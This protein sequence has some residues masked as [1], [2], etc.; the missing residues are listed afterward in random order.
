M[1]NEHPLVARFRN[2]A[3]LSAEEEARLRSL[4]ESKLHT[5]AARRDLVREGDRPRVVFLILSGWAYR[6]KT[7]PDGRRQVLQF[8]L[9][10]DLC[11]VHNEVLGEMDHSIGTITNLRYVEISHDA[12]AEVEHDYPGLRRAF[13]WHSMAAISMQREWTANIGQRSASERLAHLF[14]ELFLRLRAV[15]L[16]DDLSCELPVTQTDLGDSTGLTPVHVNRMLQELR[17]AGLIV[18]EHRRL[19]IPDLAALQKSASFSANYLHLG[20][21]DSTGPATAAGRRR[22]GVSQ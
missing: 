7:L 10:G 3:D 19:T 12:V 2:F 8:L 14:C 9:P 6:H 16:N 15:G 18:L 22:N 21:R 1:R 20:K 13:L 5:R 17:K 4:C 11:D